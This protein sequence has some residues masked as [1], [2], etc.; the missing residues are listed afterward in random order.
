M[1]RVCLTY[2][3]QKHKTLNVL[4]ELGLS[5][6]IAE[7]RILPEFRLIELKLRSIEPGRIALLIL[8][9]LNPTL[10]K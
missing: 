8:H 2:L 7:K 6:N 9:Q 5:W 1:A 10:H 4:N 3:G